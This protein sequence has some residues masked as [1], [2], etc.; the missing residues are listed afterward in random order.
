MSPEE[1]IAHERELLRLRKIARSASRDE[2]LNLLSEVDLCEAEYL[3]ITGSP[4]P[5]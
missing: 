3:Q 2:R 1:L 5:L 4:L